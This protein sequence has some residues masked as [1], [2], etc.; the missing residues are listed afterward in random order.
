MSTMICKE[1][2]HITYNM[3]RNCE[4]LYMSTMICKE[5]IHI[6]YNMYRNCEKLCMSVKK[7]VKHDA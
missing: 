5:F 2:I 3:Y 4:K 7:V 1:F 6:T